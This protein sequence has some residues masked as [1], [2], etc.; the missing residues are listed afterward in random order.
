MV[1]ECCIAVV[2]IRPEALSQLEKIKSQRQKQQ[3]FEGDEFFGPADFDILM[4]VPPPPLFECGPCSSSQVQIEQQTVELPRCWPLPG[5][6]AADAA[7]R[8]VGDLDM[9]VI[10]FYF[11]I[12]I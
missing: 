10:C 6:R 3:N 7:L 12:K 2:R 8:F 11:L 5:E 1:L 4:A 9:L